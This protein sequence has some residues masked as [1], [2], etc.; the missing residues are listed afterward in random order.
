[1]RTSS[2]GNKT[3]VP[4]ECITNK[5]EAHQ[6]FIGRENLGTTFEVYVRKEI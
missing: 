5:L 4:F 6:R 3:R 2:I 1:M